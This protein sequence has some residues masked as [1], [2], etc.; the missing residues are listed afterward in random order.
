MLAHPNPEDFS[1]ALARLISDPALRKKLGERAKV[2]SNELY[3]VEAFEKQI[4]ILYTRVLQQ[5]DHSRLI[6][7][8]TV[9]NL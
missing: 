5:I 1:A 4:A 9:G 8:K 6:A 7:S 3:T 2:V